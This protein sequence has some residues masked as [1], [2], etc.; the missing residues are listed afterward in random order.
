[1]RLKLSSLTVNLIEYSVKIA[2]L[3]QDTKAIKIKSES[4]MIKIHDNDYLEAATVCYFMSH[5]TLLCT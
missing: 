3:N 5:S 1:M 4:W 2:I